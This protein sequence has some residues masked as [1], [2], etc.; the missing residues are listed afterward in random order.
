MKGHL[1]ILI[2]QAAKHGWT[3]LQVIVTLAGTP[4]LY[5]YLCSIDL[6]SDTSKLL[7]T[8][9]AVLADVISFVI[10]WKQGG[11]AVR[12][13]SARANEA[14]NK[15]SDL[16]TTLAVEQDRVKRLNEELDAQRRLREADKTISDG[17]LD[18][19]REAHKKELDALINQHREEEK[20]LRLHYESTESLLRSEL[21]KSSNL[22][23]VDK[24]L[25]QSKVEQLLRENGELNAEV[26]RWK[27]ICTT[28]IE[29]SAA[30]EA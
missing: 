13:E 20:K 23:D 8:L 18:S 12:E 16:G 10:G 1:T 21:E 14:E 7:V 11:M 19:M 4:F 27:A 26:A 3:I 6:N 25:A 30:T 22:R 17:K 28:R 2:E 15:A 29:N 5:G 9:I 24:T